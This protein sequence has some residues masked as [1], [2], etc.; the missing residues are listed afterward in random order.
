MK[1]FNENRLVFLGNLLAKIILPHLFV[2]GRYWEGYVSIK[3]KLT[4]SR[5][6]YY[7]KLL[8]MRERLT[9]LMCYQTWIKIPV[10]VTSCICSLQGAVFMSGGNYHLRRKET[11]RFFDPVF[12]S[13][14]HWQRCF[15]LESSRKSPLICLE[16]ATIENSLWPWNNDNVMRLMLKFLDSSS[17]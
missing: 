6:V 16:V 4:C 5:L 1:I 13:I 14:A 3:L 8:W 9:L 10:P 15:F 2:L 11:H 12:D 17:L 7:W